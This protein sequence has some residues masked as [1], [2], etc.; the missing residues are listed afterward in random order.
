MYFQVTSGRCYARRAGYDTWWCIARDEAGKAFIGTLYRKG[1]ED[2]FI[3]ER[4]AE[5]FDW[6]NFQ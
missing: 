5:D 4:E 6:E 3:P 2:E 1:N